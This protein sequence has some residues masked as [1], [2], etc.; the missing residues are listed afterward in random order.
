MAVTAS[1]RQGTPKHSMSTHSWRTSD[2]V[3]GL[4]GW[5]S[6]VRRGHSQAF[7]RPQS[8]ALPWKEVGAW[9]QELVDDVNRPK[10]C[11]STG[12]P[13]SSLAFHS[14]VQWKQPNYISSPFPYSF[15]VPCFLAFYRAPFRISV[16]ILLNSNIKCD[17]VDKVTNWWTVTGIE[18]QLVQRFKKKKKSNVFFSIQCTVKLWNSLPRSFVKARNL[19][20]FKELDIHKNTKNAQWYH[21]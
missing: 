20:S 13:L 2:L 3:L 6:I 17:K 5:S 21:H 18:V 15:S 12:N 4:W 1:P 10:E 14:W 16:C 7:Q 9:E 19:S 11:V 8:W